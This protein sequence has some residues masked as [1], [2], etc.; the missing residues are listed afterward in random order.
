MKNM[1]SGRNSYRNRKNIVFG[2]FPKKSR[3]EIF[4]GHRKIFDDRKNFDRHLEKFLITQKN[5]FS[6]ENYFDVEKK[7]STD[8]FVNHFSLSKNKFE[9]TFFLTS[10]LLAKSLL[11]PT[12]T[13]LVPRPGSTIWVWPMQGR[14][15]NACLSPW[16]ASSMVTESFEHAHQTLRIIQLYHGA[17]PY[18]I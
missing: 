3:I 1:V 9:T 10:F 2:K 11:P 4:F 14:V 13:H 12:Q 18:R 5:I 16:G 6:I 17:I 15:P 8:F 7:I